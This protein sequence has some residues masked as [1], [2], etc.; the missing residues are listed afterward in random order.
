MQASNSKPSENKQK[1]ARPILQTV[2]PFRL[3]FA[4]F[5][6]AF[7]AVWFAQNSINTYWEQKYHE[8]SV[9]VYFNKIPLWKTG[10]DLQ[11]ACYAAY[12]RFKHKIEEVDNQVIAGGTNNK[13][14]SQQPAEAQK[15]TSSDTGNDE[16]EAQNAPQT[17]ENSRVDEKNSQ[18][19]A[20]IPNSAPKIVLESLQD[21][22]PQ[23]PQIQNPQLQNENQAVNT[24]GANIAEK[25][26]ENTQNLEISQEQN[27]QEISAK[28]QEI[29]QQIA[30]ENKKSQETENQNFVIVDSPNQQKTAD[31]Q[32]LEISQ[33][34]NEENSSASQNQ[35]TDNA[36]NQSEEEI[37]KNANSISAIGAK[38][39]TPEEKPD[40]DA[41]VFKPSG[42]LEPIVR[43]S[44][45]RA[46]ADLP[47][48]GK[49]YIPTVNQ[50]TVKSTR[51]SKTAIPDYGNK[52]AVVTLN[53]GDK[54]FFAGDSMMQGLAP[55]VQRWLQKEAG[56]VS[57]N[58]SK[59]STGLSYTK[60]FDWPK[61][62][63]DTF[64]ANPEIKLLIVFVGANDPWG[65]PDPNS[66]KK[67]LQFRSDAWANE[68]AA[69]MQRMIAA[70]ESRG[71]A[72]I[73]VGI[74]VMR[75]EEYNRKMEFIDDVIRKTLTGR[76]IY[77]PIR[78]LFTEN[79]NNTYT[80]S[81]DIAGKIT[82]VRAK[83]GIH[84]TPAGYRR[85]AQAVQGK[86][87]I[88]KQSKQSNW[89]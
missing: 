57:I 35:N 26:T 30:E 88:N 81:I 55:F 33:S 19:A 15:K 54:V 22:E 62:V 25:T 44:N 64:A 76:G 77:I 79:A 63:E 48:N 9:L 69:R 14:G 83:D 75:S 72:V 65:F 87:Y 89:E 42:N 5:V 52:E 47:P 10:A 56:I 82:R 49:T 80:D 28:P 59:Q 71:A 31:T 21:D 73:W 39:L 36:A 3:S 18:N 40:G 37:A 13:Q 86:I 74:P 43:N 6:I 17:A 38:D 11:E 51:K 32:N 23:N 78:R 67:I 53:P 61:T 16:I 85:I 2:S 60:A 7:F 68:Y 4:L 24:D 45:L 41:I 12:D 1:R 58:L 46:N 34:A 84:F 50:G 70:A 8:Q 29:N 20:N 27:P 66:P